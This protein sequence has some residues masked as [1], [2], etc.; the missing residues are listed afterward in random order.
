MNCKNQF[1]T[2]FINVQQHSL[3]DF[4]DY[5][6]WYFRV[7]LYNK[8]KNAIKVKSLSACL[9]VC[10][11][12]HMYTINICKLL[13]LIIWWLWRLN[14]QI[15]NKTSS[16]LT[17]IPIAIVFKST[18]YAIFLLSATPR[19]LRSLMRTLV[20]SNR[21]YN[22]AQINVKTILALHYTELNTHS[23]FHHQR[24]K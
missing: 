18:R 1:F 23:T 10:L 9:S 19:C 15:L 2:L 12:R 17:F 13:W 7:W 11:S 21:Y 8:Q 14:E 6:N 3:T 16:D 24:N 20:Q 5:R 4:I 22:T